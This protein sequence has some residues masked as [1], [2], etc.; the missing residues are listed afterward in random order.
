MPTAQAIAP[1]VSSE[2]SAPSTQWATAGSRRPAS[3]AFNSPRRSDP[4]ADAGGLLPLPD[5]DFLVEL[6]RARM[7]LQRVGLLRHGLRIEQ[8]EGWKRRSHG[9]G[10]LIHGLGQL[11]GRVVRGLDVAEDERVVG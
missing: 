3:P 6:H 2:A 1:R 10:V 4:L 7:V 8:P 11:V 9:L 5:A